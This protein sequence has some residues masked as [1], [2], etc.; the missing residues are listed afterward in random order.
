MH[1]LKKILGR[2]EQ[3]HVS[4]DYLR[5]I[6]LAMASLALSFLHL[7]KFPSIWIFFLNFTKCGHWENLKI[8]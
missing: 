5:V 1:T 3:H 2:V 7:P 4:K 6:D 8:E